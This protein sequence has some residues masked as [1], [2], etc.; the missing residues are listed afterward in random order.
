[1]SKLRAGYAGS[2]S[3]DLCAALRARTLIHLAGQPKN[4]PFRLGAA[5]TMIATFG[6]RQDEFQKHTVWRGDHKRS[7][8]NA[9]LEA[10]RHAATRCQRAK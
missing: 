9:A 8:F 2:A 1:M 6:E 10:A 4:L 5:N 7:A 3:A